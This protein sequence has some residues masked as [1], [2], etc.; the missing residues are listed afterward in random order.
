[1]SLRINRTILPFLLYII[2]S[3]ASAQELYPLNE[4]AS[5]VPKG[6]IGVRLITH[7]YK[8]SYVFRGSQSFRVMYGLSSRLSVMAT[9]SFSNHH[10]KKLPPDLI[11][12]THTGAQTNFYTRGFKRG[13]AYPYQ[14]NGLYFF[15]KYR[16]LSI[17][18]QNQHFRMAVYGEWSSVN[19]AHDE[20]E[21]NLMDDTGG[22]GYG[23]VGTFLKNRFAVSVTCGVIRP[24]SYFEQ[25]PDFTG[26]LDLPTRIH[27]GNAIKY[28]ISFGYRH[29]PDHYTDYSQPNWNYYLE[30]MGK[31]YDAARVIQSGVEIAPRTPIL[32]SG[33]YL[34]V[35]PGIQY[36]ANS[37]LRIEF[38]LGLPVIGSSYAHFPPVWTLAFQRYFYRA[39][40]TKS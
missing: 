24:N 7:G 11:Y 39:Q 21:P 19:I 3:R 31:S 38:S 28:N 14:F 37:N 26:G 23:A 12:H 25:Q 27:Y 32:R 4:P 29:S 2:V 40:K 22:Y 17:D 10:N 5:S 33:F 20:A 18:K 6:V 30:F 35:Y 8:E 9:G 16:F 1:M 15:A 13:K 34:E 36:I